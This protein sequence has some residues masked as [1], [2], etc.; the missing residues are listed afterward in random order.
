M[1]G[2]HPEEL[3]LLAYVDEELDAA[4]AREIAEHV[5]ACAT[6]AGQ[7]RALAAGR[8][9]LRG[10]P[11]LELPAHRRG[12]VLAELPARE[13]APRRAPR[14]LLALVAALLAVAALAAVVA[15][16]EL[17]PPGGGDDA[18]G[19]AEEAAQPAPPAGEG[20]RADTTAPDAAAAQAPLAEVEGPP[21]RV[22]DFLRE[23]GYRV[24]VVDGQVEVR[25][26]RPAAVER[27][28][29]KRFARGDVLVYAK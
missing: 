7:V 15:T 1:A 24:R 17:A 29:T 10:A 5:G 22:A 4:R 18:G 28:L 16:Q 19:R 14:R 26:N 13:P 25:T 9:A 21:S 3:D 2:T 20:E 11:A 6:C 8:D 27:L 12:R 23:R